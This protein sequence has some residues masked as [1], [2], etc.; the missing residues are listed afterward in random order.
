MLLDATKFTESNYAVN[1]L[2]HIFSDEHITLQYNYKIA[3]NP[4]IFEVDY[5]ITPYNITKNVLIYNHEACFYQMNPQPMQALPE[6]TFISFRKG[7]GQESLGTTEN[8]PS[9][10]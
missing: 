4:S 6:K 5:L 10:Q 3:H 2:K 7:K 8:S 9:Y 1:P